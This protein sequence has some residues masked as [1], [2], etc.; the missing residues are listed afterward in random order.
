MLSYK[1]HS[2][3][4]YKKINVYVEFN[5]QIKFE[6]NYFNIAINFV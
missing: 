3:V 2:I 1:P 6:K 4:P 5:Y